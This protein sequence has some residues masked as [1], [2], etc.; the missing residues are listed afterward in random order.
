MVFS[1]NMADTIGCAHAS[2]INLNWIKNLKVKHKTVKLPED[3][4]GENLDHLG[5][6]DDV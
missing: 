4:R 2:E 3:N 5:Y 1:T 6:G